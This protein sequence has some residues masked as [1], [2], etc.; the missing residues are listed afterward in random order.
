MTPSSG[1][2]KW[3]VGMA[4]IVFILVA[5]LLG[6]CSGLTRTEPGEVALIRNGG[7]FDTTD[8]R[9]TKPVNSGYSFNGLASEVR[10]YI[11]SDQQ[12]F[13][14]VSSDP[15]RADNPNV[16]TIEVPTRDGVTV[17]IEGQTLFHTVFTGTEDDQALR[18]FDT[19]YGNRELTKVGTDDEKVRVWDG[20]EGWDAF[21]DTFFRPVL[22]STLREEVGGLP[23]EVLVSSCAVLD[24][25]G[26]QGVNVLA[27]GENLNDEA[28]FQKVQ[29]DV[30][31]KLQTRIDSALSGHYLDEF[32]FELVSV[33][34]AS[35]EVQNRIDSAQAAAAGIAEAKADAEAAKFQATGAEDLVGQYGREAAAQIK[36]AET[37]KDSNATVI[38][39]GSS[40]GLNL[41]R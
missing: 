9:T 29:A 37:L 30:E 33:K 27:E 31:A 36:I 3:M 14:Y 18:D 12:R 38:L 23:C 20:D 32:Q 8:I 34:P 7:P 21:L 13:Y 39:G 15:E 2:W 5:L 19:A 1:G 26:S 24:Q 17:K 41:A 28:A 35:E 6:S 22:E 10:K 25:A 4:L 40:F 11:A 16:T